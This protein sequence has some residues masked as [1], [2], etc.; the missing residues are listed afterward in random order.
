MNEV[1]FMLGDQGERIGD[2]QR[3]LACLGLFAGKQTL[4]FDDSLREALIEFQR[5]RKLPPN[6]EC[7]TATWN[8]LNDQA[9]SL[10]SEAF[11]FELDAL[12]GQT[13]DE[14]VR[15]AAE[16]EVIR[17]A[18]DLN[19][20]GLAFSG[21]GIRSATFNLGILQALAEHKLLRDFDYLSTVSGGGYIGGWFSKWLKEET[22]N[23]KGD[24]VTLEAKL[25][26]GSKA[27]P[28]TDE[29][30]QI[31]FLR[32]YSNYLTPKTGMFS[33]DTWSV[34]ATYVRNTM[35]NLSILIALMAAFLVLPRVLTLLVSNY[36]GQHGMLF[37]LIGLAAF[38]WVVYFIALSI[39]ITPDPESRDPIFSQTQGSIIRHIVVPLMLAGFA[40]SIGLWEAMGDINDSWDPFV[41]EL[42]DPGDPPTI[43]F[44]WDEKRRVFEFALLPG[45]VYFL[46]WLAGWATAQYRSD[47]SDQEK[48][49]WTNLGKEGLGHLL[50][51][52]LALGLGSLLVFL[53]LAWLEPRVHASA[54]LNHSSNLVG[55][56]MPLL[57]CIF[58]ITMVLLVGLIGRLYTDSSREWWSRL[59]GWTIILVLSWVGVFV[60]AFYVPPTLFWINAN[61]PAWGAAVIASGWL[62]TTI[63][64]VLAGAGRATGDRKGTPWLEFLAQIA[65]YVFTLG[66]VTAIATLVHFASVPTG[67]EGMNLQDANLPQYIDRY[68]R[69]IEA[70]NMGHL[71]IIMGAFLVVGLL[72]AWRVDIN[73]FSL[74]MMYRNRL[75]RAYLG[76]S[77][78]QRRPHPFTAFDPKDDPG[79]EEFFK[80]D[81]A[82][83]QKPYH[84]VNAALNLV[85]GKELAWQTRKASGFVFTPAFCGFEMPSMPYAG[86]PTASQHA[87]RGC[88][89][90]TAQFGAKHTRVNDEDAGTKLGMAMAVSGAA[91]S[92]S[93]GYHS[94]P[95]LA[96]LMTIFNVRLGRWCPNPR[97]QKLWKHSGPQVGLFWLIAELF[98]LTDA[99]A[100][101]LYLSDGG[102]FENLGIYELVRRRCR[103]IVVVDAGAD[104]KM[105]FEDLGN[106]IRKC[107][108]DLS[109]EID[110]NVGTI[111]REPAVEFS[112][113][114]CVAG[115]ILYG[116]VDLGAPDGTL[117][118]IK[119]SLTGKELADVLNYRKTDPN[120]PHQ[121]TV[122]QWFDETE[123]E[124]YRSLG[125][126]IGNTAV[127]KFAR[128]SEIN[129][130]EPLRHDIAKLCTAIQGK[131]NSANDEKIVNSIARA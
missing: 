98:G 85:K 87:A 64:G 22:V 26:P 122:D 86:G 71:F 9:G 78:K 75:V 25:T 63:A 72:L 3:K 103:L 4:K 128:A 37:L 97:S 112:K 115:K 47:Q 5:A 124:S 92:P 95:P 52:I 59:G 100:D 67:M 23:E 125:Y 10:F 70:S 76:A 120:F 50:F 41:K 48:V 118:Y 130:V 55:F 123:F 110:I 30:D 96:F 69:D 101:F 51:A 38:L 54:L 44:L 27:A 79:F 11:Q 14:G 74:Y 94:S 53:T 68:L 116:K 91:V 36:K 117:L 35:L 60:V 131:W 21:G 73:K 121:G 89:R 77:S 7:D 106:A 108:T 83:T 32:Q 34:I 1:T 107:Y 65:P 15:P 49:K 111:D 18:H 45:I 33:A 8:E 29:P 16:S 82:K 24:I 109:I 40:G 66:I 42:Y 2:I 84:I 114:H 129:T 104:G 6:G 12:R 93:M 58:G 90:P 127:D 61:A 105:N 88:F 113:A 13:T 39:S 80:P 20:A 17:R 56:G 19:L 81:G 31:K 126:H 43:Q 119:P 46:V 62:G 99:D 57:L 28:V 102:H